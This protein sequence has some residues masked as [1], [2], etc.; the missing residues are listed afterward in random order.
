[1]KRT[2]FI[3]LF[4]LL[5]VLFLQTYDTGSLLKGQSLTDFECDT[6]EQGSCQAIGHTCY[7]SADPSL[8]NFTLPDGSILN[9]FVLG[10]R[11]INYTETIDGYTILRDASGYYFYATQTSDGDLAISAIQAHNPIARDEYERSYLTTVQRHLR[12]TGTALADIKATIPNSGPP[13]ARFPSSGTNKALMLLVNFASSAYSYQ[14][15]DFDD[16]ANGANYNVNGQTGSFREYYD[17]VSDGDLTIDTDV[18]GWIEASQ[19]SE[20]Y[21]D[22]NEIGSIGYVPLLVQEAIENSAG[23]GNQFC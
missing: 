4:V 7:I 21:N 13:A 19:T 23:Q 22:A 14:I 12:L 9:G 20:F 6:D 5:C 1:M 17:D 3:R 2:N 10:N 8:R 16:L 15:S 11:F 18:F